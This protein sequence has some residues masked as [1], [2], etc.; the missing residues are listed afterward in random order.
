MNKTR[1]LLSDWGNKSTRVSISLETLQHDRRPCDTE[2]ETVQSIGSSVALHVF[3]W[4]RQR[5]DDCARGP[6]VEVERISPSRRGR[7]WGWL[8]RLPQSA[9]EYFV[10]D[11]SCRLDRCRHRGATLAEGLVFP[12]GDGVLATRRRDKMKWFEEHSAHFAS[13]FILQKKIPFL[14]ST[15]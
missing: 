2:E 4:W 3:P 7:R 8:T 9:A 1:A 11:S 12:S 6:A 15:T 10:F 5:E 14:F 13:R